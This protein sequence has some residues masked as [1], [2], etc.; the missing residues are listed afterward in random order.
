M[1]ARITGAALRG[2]LV[3]LMVVTPALYLPGY[4]TDS[5]EIVVLLAILAFVL[6]FAEYNSTF[7]SFI[8]FRDAPPLNRLRFIALMSMVVLLTLICKHKY[9]PTNVTT[10]FAGMG[11][12]IAHLVDFPFSPVRLVVLML[13]DHATLSTV[14][15]VRIAAGVSYVVALATVAAFYIAVRVRGWPVGNG[16]FNVWINL[17]LFDP[18]TGGDVVS[19]LQRDGRINVVLGV[20]LPFFIPAVVKATADLVNPIMLDN[21]QTLIWTMSAWAFLPASMIMR[22]MAMLRVSDLIEEKRRRT[23][24]NAEAVQT[25]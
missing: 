1:I 15:S 11:V 22:G 18:T 9:A 2:I 16:A 20:L 19:R 12:L 13:P 10:L 21:P 25:A 6:T 5:P 8:E 3:A 17:P 7:P 23:Y 14:N 4:T 24:A